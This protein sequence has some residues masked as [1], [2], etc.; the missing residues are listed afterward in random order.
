MIVEERFEDREAGNKIETQIGTGREGWFTP[1]GLP[2]F[3]LCV[4]VG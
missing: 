4:G 1:A 2:H 3:A